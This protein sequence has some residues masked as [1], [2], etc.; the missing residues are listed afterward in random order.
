MEE[1]SDIKR[2]QLKT[3]PALHMDAS[4]ITNPCILPQIVHKINQEDVP[5]KIRKLRVSRAK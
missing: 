4:L 2:D 1:K 3:C 5:L